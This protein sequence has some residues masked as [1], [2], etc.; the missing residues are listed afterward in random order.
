MID[1]ELRVFCSNVRGLIN[2]WSSATNF[3]W[4]DYDLLGF[5]EIWGIKEFENLKVNG[6]KVISCR[7]RVERRGGGSII[8]G[9]ENLNG[10]V[11][12]T[13]FIEGVIESTGIR[14]N[15]VTFVNIYR[16]PS[17]N[18]TEFVDTLTQ[19]LD[20]IRGN[21]ILIGGDFNL[22]TMGN[23][24][25]MNN[26]CS[27]YD[28]E[29]KINEITRI[30]SGTCIDNYLTNIRGEFNV[31]DICIA[32]HQAIIARIQC[33][34]QNNSGP[35][36]Y[37]Y[38]EM[39]E[40]NWLCFKAG[41]N[42]LNVR[43]NNINEKWSNLLDD[44]KLVVETSFPEKTRKNKYMF[45]MSQGLLKSKDKKN[46]LLSQYKRGLIGK[47]IYVRYNKIYRKLIWEEQ[48]KKFEEKIMEAG[49]SGKK[50]WKVLK[51]KL[52][53]QKENSKISEI[54]VDGTFL[55]EEAEISRPFKNH[56]E[57][58]AARLAEGLPLGKILL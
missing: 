2:N 42:T 25:F 26:I 50:K 1:S 13:P 54:C 8:F 12:N 14:V 53:L 19:Y 4:D 37:T 20:T 31:S 6:Y 35:V 52:F 10:K 9:K 21:K 22:D 49:G 56:F 5:N 11:L 58:C 38:R 27:L 17:G 33:E 7:Q 44:I 3:K 30:E 29:I 34:N 36:T 55:T 39:K 40:N 18:K 46:K 51:E 47:E 28:L 15:G 45:T 57:T 41:I 24:F 32:D 48:N 16:P 43:G 23:N